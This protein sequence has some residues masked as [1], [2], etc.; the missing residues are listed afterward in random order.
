MD[1]AKSYLVRI[2]LPYKVTD[3]NRCLGIKTTG[4]CSRQMGLKN[5]STKIC[6]VTFA[7]VF[8][9][10]Y[11]TIVHFLLFFSSLNKFCEC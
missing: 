9:L 4:I 1:N 2:P 7:G 11:S 5:R 3:E 8:S 10:D 6:E